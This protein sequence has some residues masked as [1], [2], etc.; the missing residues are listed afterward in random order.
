MIENEKIVYSTNSN[1]HE[2][3]ISGEQNNFSTLGLY[4]DKDGEWQIEEYL[5]G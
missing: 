2:E 1:E 4:Q 5:L 3:N